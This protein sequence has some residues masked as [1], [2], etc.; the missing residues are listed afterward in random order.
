MNAERDGD[1]E[2]RLKGVL[3]PIPPGLRERI[4][5]GAAKRKKDRT[6]LTPL[7]RICLVVSTVIFVAA[8]AADAV[9]THKEAI[10]TAALIGPAGQPAGLI[11][12]PIMRAD[13]LAAIP[14]AEI[15]FAERDARSGD[16]PI[17]RRLRLSGIKELL[18]EESDAF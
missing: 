10:R 18:K 11:E 9:L 14:R 2:Q 17:F 12:D 4:L 7:L 3:P 13:I 5:N 8:L 16:K 6:A 1:I 15:T